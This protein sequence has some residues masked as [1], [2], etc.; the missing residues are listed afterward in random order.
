MLG[1]LGVYGD[2]ASMAR[3]WLSTSTYRLALFW[4]SSGYFS[5]HSCGGH[6]RCCRRLTNP[7]SADS[8]STLASTG[9][10]NTTFIRSGSH[11]RV[12][13]SH[14]YTGPSTD[15]ASRCWETVEISITENFIIT[16][17]KPLPLGPPLREN[18]S[19][20]DL[21]APSPSHDEPT[22]ATR[23]PTRP[24]AAAIRRSPDTERSA[25]Y[26]TSTSVEAQTL[27]HPT[28]HTGSMAEAKTS[29]LTSVYAAKTSLPFLKLPPELRNRILV[30]TFAGSVTSSTRKKGDL[31]STARISYPR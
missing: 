1:V 17:P 28:P 15:T 18:A 19:K 8:A 21:E 14:Q 6:H 13:T 9:D 26:F 20:S 16:D 24:V 5:F 12:K 10:G 2:A 4:I 23:G 31:K 22:G 11:K 25:E 30:Y 29:S 7:T 3:S 27:H